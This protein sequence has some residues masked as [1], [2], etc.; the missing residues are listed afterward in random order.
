M[1]NIHVISHEEST[2]RLKEI[3]DNLVNTRGKLAEVH[4]IQSLRP[5]SIVKHMELYLEIMFSKSELSRAE[6]EMIA[7]VV[8]AANQCDYCQTHHAEALNHYWKDDEKVKVL[9]TN[10][11]SVDL[12]SKQMALCDYAWKLTAHP[13]KANDADLVAPL[14]LQDLSDSACLDA[15]LVIAYFNFV[16]RIVLGH[17]VNLEKSAGLGYKY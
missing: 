14:K 16:N 15:T 10:Y 1:P 11:H 13:E 7:V 9:R 17:Q 12:T 8:S 6:R 3:Y 5:E 4:M 2:G